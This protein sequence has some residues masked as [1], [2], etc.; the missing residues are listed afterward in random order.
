MHIHIIFFKYLLLV[1][2]AKQ[3]EHLV[4]FPDLFLFMK[5]C[6]CLPTYQL[7]NINTVGLFICISI[8]DSFLDLR[9]GSWRPKSVRQLEEGRPAG[10]YPKYVAHP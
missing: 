5:A 7:L 9:L 6:L 8:T 1:V 3:E 2:S 10:L 4:I